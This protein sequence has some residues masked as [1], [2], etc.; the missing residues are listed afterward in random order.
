MQSGR[1]PRHARAPTSTCRSGATAAPTGRASS[2]ATYT[3]S[4]IPASHR[5]RAVNPS[6]G[7]IISWNN[8][9]APG[10]RKGPR[11]WSNGP[12]HRALIL[13]NRLFDQVRK[14][15]AARSTS[16]ASPGR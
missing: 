6:D 7:F 13:Q 3:F 11:E 14:R 1:Y 9:E 12:V 2:P 4:A 10:W 8:K 15:A 5:P 16:P